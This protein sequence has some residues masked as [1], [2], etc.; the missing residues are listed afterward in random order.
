MEN[1][2]IDAG[3]VIELVR[4]SCVDKALVL[5]DILKYSLLDD[6]DIEVMITFES[7]SGWTN[8]RI[9]KED[10]LNRVRDNKLKVLLDE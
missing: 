2:D 8:V 9:F 10:Y 4:K 6:D 5:K 1:S 3:V 7:D